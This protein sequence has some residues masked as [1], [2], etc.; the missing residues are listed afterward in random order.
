MHSSARPS[1]PARRPRVARMAAPTALA[2]AA[3]GI[4]LASAP[5]AAAAALPASCT[6]T[7][8]DSKPI[9]EGSTSYGTLWV[10]Y[11]ASTQRNCAK[12][13][14]FDTSKQQQFT[15]WI[16]RCPEPDATTPQSCAT[17]E[18]A[19][20]GRNLDSGPYWSYAGA[21]TTLGNSSRICI[22]AGAELELQRAARYAR[23]DL[24][25]HCG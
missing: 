4:A 9:K 1:A 7:L 5:S 17:N 2:L 6:G 16:F 22:Y 25:G 10:Y 19:V 18:E 11:N 12:A 8:I 14:K 20:Q 3:S 15:V 24:V 13:T 23:A 21:V